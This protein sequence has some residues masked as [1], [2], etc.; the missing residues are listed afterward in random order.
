MPIMPNPPIV[1]I[2]K[3]L[4]LSLNISNLIGDLPN[5]EQKVKPDSLLWNT[6]EEQNGWKLQTD[7]LTGRARV[8]DSNNIR[9]ANGSIAVMREKMHRLASGH[10]LRPGDII[11]VS[12]MLYDHYAIYVGNN[13]VVHYAAPDNEIG[14]NATIHEA[15]FDEFM[16]SG[17]TYFILS[18]CGK[19]PVR[20]HSSTSFTVTDSYRQLYRPVNHSGKIN[21]R[22]FTPEETIKRAYSRI[23]ETRYNLLTNNCEH[24]ALWCKTGIA[25]SSQVEI[26]KSLVL[27][28]QLTDPLIVYDL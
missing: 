21:Y 11:G 12:R 5:I 18:F 14:R 1:K 6:I 25:M 4:S 10:F 3:Q 15:D 24:F 22:I 27:N 8:L 16:G 17:K 2:P 7:S 20:V 26:F 19:Y 28:G 13:R 9:K 23:G